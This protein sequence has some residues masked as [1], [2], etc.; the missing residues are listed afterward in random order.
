MQNTLSG[1]LVDFLD[2]SGDGL[3]FVSAAPASI[4]QISLFSPLFLKK[5]GIIRLIPKRVLDGDYFYSLFSQI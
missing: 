1:S 4:A 3:G 2:R 5:Q